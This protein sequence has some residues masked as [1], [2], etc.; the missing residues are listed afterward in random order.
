PAAS[1]STNIDGPGRPDVGND[2]GRA[3]D[4]LAVGVQAPLADSGHGTTRWRIERWDEQQTERAVRT[5]ERER[6]I[7]VDRKASIAISPAVFR[8]LGIQPYEISEFTGNL[9]T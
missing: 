3:T 1:R 5:L 7:R 4:R 8:R 6:S 2:N 9:I